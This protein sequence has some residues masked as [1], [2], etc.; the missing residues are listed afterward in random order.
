MKTIIV[1]LTKSS[2]RAGPFNISDEYNDIIDVNVSRSSLVEG[3]S[4]VIN[5]N[6][7]VIT[8][9][10]IGICK[11]TFSFGIG[12]ITPEEI[13]SSTYTITTNSCI[14]RHLIY[15]D[16]YNNFYGNIEPYI[17]EYPFSYKFQDEILQNVKDYTK[18]YKFFPDID[19]VTDEFD[20]IEVND[21]YFNKSTIYNDQQSTGLLELVPKPIN[22]LQTYLTFPKYN[23]L[24]KTITFAKRDNFYQY[25][26]FWN[27]VK[28][29]SI[30][31]FTRT[32]ESLSI[33]KII[34]QSNMDYTTRSF[35]K[36][37]IRAKDTKIRHTLDDRSD[38]NLVSQFILA[39]SQISYI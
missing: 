3:K 16:V 23:P 32:C 33:D 39:P 7:N 26:T 15:P 1:K 34:N 14:W 28:N 25:N 4:Y 36:Q 12:E 27:V 20:R 8:L 37:T 2:L 18:T 11:G 31:L 30:P 38:I 19:G 35:K 29:P 22:N 21:V 9:S 13:A 24:S 6:V 17:I 10:S 5:D